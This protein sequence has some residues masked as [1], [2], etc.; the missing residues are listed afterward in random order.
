[1]QKLIEDAEAIFRAAVR[2]VQADV[3]FGGVDLDAL[4]SRP[5]PSFERVAVVGVGKA[6]MAMAGVLEARLGRPP[7]VGL[8]VV[9]HGYPASF[10]ARLPRPVRIEVVEAGHPVPDAAGVAAARRLLD[11]ARVCGRGDL[12]IVLLSGGGSA[13]APAT[14]PGVS[15]SDAQDT[16]RV[17]LRSGVEVGNINTVRKHLST[18]GGGRLAVAAAPACVLAL[19]VSDVVGDDASVVASGP[20][21]PDPT[22]FEDALAVVRRGGLQDAIPASVL[23]HLTAG[24]RDPSMETPKPGDPVFDNVVTRLVGQNAD[25]VRAAASKARS[26]GYAPLIVAEGVTGEARM[27][28][29]RLAERAL[30]QARGPAACLLWGGETTV[31][32]RGRGRGGRNSELALSAALTLAGSER[33]V[34]FLSGGTDGIDGPTDAAGALVTPQTVSRAREQGI[35]ARAFLDDNDAF[36]FFSKAGGLLVTGPTHTNVMDVQI[37]LLER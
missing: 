24:A 9:P 4:L 32:V 23:A 18:F 28:G 1:M 25:A 31:T 37:A 11:V 8:V 19:V 5:V 15:L 27:V 2:A 20:T 3:L 21:V 30:A 36:T 6:A 7:S 16:I 29:R 14:L 26:L 10:P 17:L 13:L 35:E 22:R 12:L 33:R 34:A